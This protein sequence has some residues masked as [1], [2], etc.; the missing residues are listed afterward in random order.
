MPCTNFTCDI[1]QLAIPALT[2]SQSLVAFTRSGCNEV[3][4]L[5]DRC[6]VAVVA[7]LARM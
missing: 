5:D 2:R 6:H 4:D 1:N 7:G 3:G